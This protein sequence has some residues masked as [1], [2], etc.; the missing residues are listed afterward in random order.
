MFDRIFSFLR[1]PAPD[2]GTGPVA[3][4]HDTA[5]SASQAQ[6]AAPPR[7][8]SSSRGQ[9]RQRDELAQRRLRHAFIAQPG[10]TSDARSS[11]AQDGA[12]DLRTG[13]L[14][15]QILDALDRPLTDAQ[16]ERALSLLLE[17]EPG[18]DVEKRALMDE[19][20]AFLASLP[21]P[22]QEASEHTTQHR[23]SQP[24]IPSTAVT[25][26]PRPN[27]SQQIDHA[28][29]L[30]APASPVGQPESARPAT[31]AARQGGISSSPTEARNEQAISGAALRLHQSRHATPTPTEVTP[32]NTPAALPTQAQ[33][34][35]A[36]TLAQDLQSPPQAGRRSLLDR[37]LAFL[38]SLP[39]PIQKLIDHQNK[40]LTQTPAMQA[41]L[42]EL[43]ELQEQARRLEDG[44]HDAP[45][46]ATPPTPAPPAPPTPPAP[47][48]PTPAPQPDGAPS[49]VAA[50]VPSRRTTIQQQMHDLHALE[51]EQA[52]L[53][54][55][56]ELSSPAAKLKAKELELRMAMLVENMLSMMKMIADI[57][58]RA[59]QIATN[60]I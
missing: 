14:E 20:A 9:M 11:P 26:Q 60:A 46:A 24:A 6:P 34:E 15:A 17:S 51:A 38:S 44:P 53:A 50:P 7:S 57:N 37:G 43:D 49:P 36:E 59:N 2:N 22:A 55:Q 10:S 25:T 39:N 1:P 8:P 18:S 21:D 47:A 12:A 35:E 5:G 52:I 58:K 4:A 42:R 31:A 45:P 27:Q 30:S 3:A 23:T 56:G 16:Q 13:D 33:A 41:Q 54:E 48:T 40:R 32:D 19:M 29:T 28:P